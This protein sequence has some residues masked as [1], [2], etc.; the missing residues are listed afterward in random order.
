MRILKL[1]ATALLFCAVATTSCCCN[2][3]DDVKNVIVMVGDGMG[4]THVTQAMYLSEDELFINRVDNIA[5]TTTHSASDIVT[6]SAASGTAFAIGHKTNN[7]VLGMDANLQPQKS[8]L[9]ASKESGMT[10]GLVATYAITHATP[11]AYYAHNV[12]R[13]DG[14]GIALDMMNDYV[15][16]FIGGGRDHFEKRKDERNLTQE[17]AAKGYNVAYTIEEAESA[18]T[19]KLAALLADNGLAKMID[20]RSDMLPR[21]TT[22]ILNGLKNL[23]GKDGF[24]VMIEGSQID[25]L[26]HDNHAQGTLE[27]TLDFNKA[28]KI[29]FDFA[30]ENP[31]TLVLVF[32]DH[33][34]GGLTL[35]AKGN[36]TQT[37]FS[38]GGHTAAMIPLYA[39]GAGASSFYG[40]MD[41]TEIPKRIAKLL[42]IEF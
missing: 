11:A 34:T 2:A 5:L 22:A 27:E 13:R 15:D 20:G 8:I 40:V 42:E 17:L 37:R 7:G 26:S 6:D 32:A 24:F 3:D 41:N 31:G 23:G 30:D 21:A 18:S 33:E 38:T 9:E 25:G 36:E 16:M 12:T 4:L 1:T 10:T 19:G 28:V 35:P 14:E 39:Y 29:A